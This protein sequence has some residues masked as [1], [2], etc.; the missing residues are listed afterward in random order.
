MVAVKDIDTYIALQPENIRPAL[1]KL[2]AVIR[3]VAR[4]AQETIGYSMPMFR[5]HGML[6]GFAGWKNHYGFYPCG[7]A[8]LDEM[9][10]ELKG[11]RTSKGTIQF[12]LDK[13]LPVALIKKIVKLRMKQN[14]EKA[15]AKKK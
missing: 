6:V 2:R 10:E 8:V 14:K 5:Y 7:S 1:E 12:A 4:D 15:Q 9:Q 11:Y 13:P 3:S